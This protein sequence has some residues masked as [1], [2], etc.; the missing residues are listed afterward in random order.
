MSRELAK[1]R[2][3]RNQKELER[4]ARGDWRHKKR[5]G[6]GDLSDSDFDDEEFGN[7]KAA[8]QAKAKKRKLQ[9]KDQ[10]DDLGASDP[11]F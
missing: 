5:G 11:S 8:R 7:N 9:G 10:M 4:I 3:E 2:D 6:M 1:L